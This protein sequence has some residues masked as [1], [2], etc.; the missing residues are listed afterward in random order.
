MEGNKVP[1]DTALRRVYYSSLGPVSY[2]D[3]VVIKRA[4]LAPE[5]LWLP[6]S[7]RDLSPSTST[8]LMPSTIRD[9]HQRQYRC[10]CTNYGLSV[11]KPRQNKPYFFLK[12]SASHIL[13]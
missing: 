2:G 3:Q 4:N 1:G 8:I 13:L 11:S 7:L 9:L 5:C 12:Y 10:D 6:D